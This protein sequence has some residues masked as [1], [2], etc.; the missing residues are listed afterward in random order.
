MKI[1][2]LLSLLGLL[3]INLTQAKDYSFE[4]IINGSGQPIL[5][6]P[7]LSSHG[8]VWN[9]TVDKYKNNYETHAL[10]LPGFAGVNPIDLSAGFLHPVKQEL[11]NYI[12]NN[13]LK[14]PIVIG[15]SL[16]GFLAM[17]MA[18]DKPNLFDKIV[19]VDSA[20]FFSALQNPL[21]TIDSAKAMAEVMKKQMQEQSKEILAASLDM[22]LPSMTLDQKNIQ[23]LKDWGLKSDGTTV[24]Q[25]MYELMTTDLRDQI[26]I[27]ES[28][29][30]LIGAWVAYKNYGATHESV[31]TNYA[32]QYSKI[33]DF[34]IY[35]TDVGH[36]FIMWD[37]PK[38]YFNKIDAFLN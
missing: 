35:L 1:K 4:V 18:I 21:A 29:V 22:M 37:D 17:L 31:K 24:S 15:H 5:L 34:Q 12:E 33:S 28:P 36:H 19:I 30:L 3:I 26:E 20:P 25:A 38:F 7:G 9:E 10:T 11:F 13:N 6:I 23:I 32:S 16:G 27:I 8:S 14:K 2:T